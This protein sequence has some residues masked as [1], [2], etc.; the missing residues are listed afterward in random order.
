MKSCEKLPIK[1][2]KFPESIELPIIKQNNASPLLEHLGP[3]M[4]L[5]TFRIF[6]NLIRVFADYRE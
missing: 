4:D 3:C 1:Y 6:L 5:V 2:N